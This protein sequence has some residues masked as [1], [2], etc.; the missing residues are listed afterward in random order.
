MAC[1][2]PKA[3][4]LRRRRRSGP[5]RSASL[6][7]AVAKG[8]PTEGSLYW[9]PCIGTLVRGHSSRSAMPA[10]ATRGVALGGDSMAEAP[11]GRALRK[12]GAAQ[13]SQGLRLVAASV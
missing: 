13:Q 10:V 1:S 5:V 12:A 9:D 4:G 6:G 7:R 2:Q 8:A 11:S 3:L